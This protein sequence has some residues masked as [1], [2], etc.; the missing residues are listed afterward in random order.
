MAKIW[1]VYAW[2]MAFQI[3]DLTAS[4]IGNCCLSHFWAQIYLCNKG[5]PNFCDM[6]SKAV[7]KYSLFMI[8]SVWVA[9]A[10][11]CH[12]HP[13]MDEVAFWSYIDSN[14]SWNWF[15]DIKL[16]L[17]QQLEGSNGFQMSKKNTQK[18][19]SVS[20]S[21][22]LE[23]NFLYFLTAQTPWFLYATKVC[24]L[25]LNCKRCAS[26]Q[27]IPYAFQMFGVLGALQEICN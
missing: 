27:I 19:H 26:I 25:D 24:N 6:G 5:Y 9:V 20:H 16:F 14:I 8:F 22:H 17:L 21:N 13:K 10:A 1:L 11:M 4:K 3:F 23:I 15:G 12:T 7:P 18:F 2:V